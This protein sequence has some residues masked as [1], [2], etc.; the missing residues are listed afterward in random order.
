MEEL[1]RAECDEESARI[2]SDYREEEAAGGE[3]NHLDGC[4]LVGPDSLNL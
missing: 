2:E 4:G 3:L 1:Y